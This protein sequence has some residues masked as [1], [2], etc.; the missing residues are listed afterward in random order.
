MAEAAPA[1]LALASLNCNGLRGSDLRAAVQGATT[2]KVA[3]LLG[4][5]RQFHVTVLLDV[6]GIDEAAMQQLLAPTH[7]WMW[8]PPSV[9]GKGRGVGS[10]I[11]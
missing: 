6:A 9:Q 1:G 11:S 2:P 3:A 7:V 10:S 8:R 4:Q 5:I